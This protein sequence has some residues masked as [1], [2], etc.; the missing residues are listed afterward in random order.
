MELP[1]TQEQ[2]IDVFKDYNKTVFPIQVLFYGLAVFLVFRLF[3]SR[4]KFIP[5]SLAFFWLWM[6][7]VYHLV[8]FSVINKAA[9][10]FGGL[11]IFQG[12]LFLKYARTLSFQFTNDLNGIAAIIFLIYALIIYPILGYAIGHT[13][14]GTPTF[15]LPCPTTIFTF[16]VLLFSDKRVP[17]PVLIIP[18]LWA[19]VGTS[20]AFSL[21]FYED[22]G[23]LIV[24]LVSIILVAR[25]NKALVNVTSQSF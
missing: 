17:I 6:G 13:Y 23:L 8:F 4:Y 19:I 2:F 10:L 24:A 7:L 1:F 14:P 12:L 22:V 18:S 20:A 3:G 5:Y 25:K 21:G 15:G 11:F 9:Y 16:G